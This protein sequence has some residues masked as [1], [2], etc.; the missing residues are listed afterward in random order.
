MYSNN[1]LNVQESV[2]FLNAC[3][4]KKTGSSLNLLTMISE[5]RM[6]AIIPHCPVGWGCRIYR[7]PLCRGVRPPLNECP[8]YDPKQSD[9]EVPM[10]LGLWGM[11]S[12]SSLPLLIG[13]LMSRMV[14]PD[15]A[16]S[17]C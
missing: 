16:L 1:I 6:L 4:K 7:L 15:R 8:D 13:P 12:I 5:S 10:M 9:G 2:T 14:A 3:T 11:R 17:M